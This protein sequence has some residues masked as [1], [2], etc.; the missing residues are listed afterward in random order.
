M[1]I[2]LSDIA[3]LNIKVS[4]YCCI[5]RLVIKNQAINLMK[6]VDSTKVIRTL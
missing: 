6:K 4:D 3:I 2:S 1:S 5:V